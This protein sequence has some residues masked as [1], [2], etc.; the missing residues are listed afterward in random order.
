MREEEKPLFISIIGN[1]LLSILKI[2]IGYY[3]NSIAIISDGIHS[4]SDIVTSIISLFGV[5]IAIKPPDEDHHYGHARF[6]PLISFIIGLALLFT[7]Y[8]IFKCSLERIM[9]VTQL[10]VNYIMI[11]VIIISIIA[12][13]LMAR[14]SIYVGKKLGNQILIADAYHHRSDVYSSLAV[15][16]GLLLEKIGFY[17]GDGLAG[18]VVSFMIAKMAT[19]LCLENIDYLTGKSPNNEI[20]EKI[21]NEAL[22]VEKVLGVHDLKAQYVGK[23]LYVE[24][25]VEVPSNISAKELHDI[26]V[27]VKKRLESLEEV[28]KAYVHVDLVEK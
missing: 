27:E 19:N 1:F 9:N 11:S 4:L 13:E 16:I 17:Y 28:E 14:Y 22:K 7:S 24:L 6:E 26:E 3:F 20:L 18:I 25:H 2:I 8:E 15:L 10:E 23:W 12:K 21:K 5:K